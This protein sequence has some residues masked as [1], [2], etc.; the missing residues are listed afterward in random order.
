MLTRSDLSDEQL[1]DRLRAGDNQSFDRLYRQ[2]YPS[3]EHFVLQNNGSQE[4]ANDLFQETL[5]SL[6]TTIG[7]ADFQLRSSLKTYVFAISK[8]LWLKHLKKS[9]RWTRLEA[10]DEWSSAVPPAEMDTPPT[11]YETVMVIML[12]LSARCLKLLSAIF[13]GNKP[14]TDIVKEDGYASVHSAQNQ[15]YKCLQQARKVGG[16]G[17]VAP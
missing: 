4:Q 9:A 11:A 7:D 14:I 6:L 15:K 8:N 13:F 12:K 16:N 10:A 1:L 2:C 17:R 3:I 5:L